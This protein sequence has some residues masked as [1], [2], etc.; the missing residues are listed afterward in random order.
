MD[1][2]K[3]KNVVAAATDGKNR[4]DKPGGKKVG[5]RTSF[6]TKGVDVNYSHTGDQ[7]TNEALEETSGVREEGFRAVGSH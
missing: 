2:Q 4:W 1:G 3:Q 7:S 6:R 5:E